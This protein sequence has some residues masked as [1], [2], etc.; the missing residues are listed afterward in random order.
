AARPRVE[1]HLVAAVRRLAL[2]RRQIGSVTHDLY[3]GLERVQRLRVRLW[4]LQESS[5]Q[6]VSKLLRLSAPVANGN[7]HVEPNRAQR[8]AIQ[9][10]CRILKMGRD[11][12]VVLGEELRA[13]R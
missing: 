11:E 12:L 1:A 7:G 10:A 2:T 9:R 6:P 4:R 5:G 8:A 3:R 13:T